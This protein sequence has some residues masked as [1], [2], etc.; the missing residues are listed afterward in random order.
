MTEIEMVGWHHQ[1]NG[2]EFEQALGDGE[3]QGRLMC[4]SHGVAESDM[5]EQP[6]NRALMPKELRLGSS[7]LFE[8]FA[9]V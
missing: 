5:T 8:A 3:G 6:N 2:P 4:C 9:A 7:D 1:L